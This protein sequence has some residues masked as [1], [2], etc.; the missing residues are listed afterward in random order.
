MM[1]VEARRAERV[2]SFLRARIVFNNH[3]T[4]IECTIKNI[5]A[6]GAKI[7]LSN[8][9]SIPETFVLEVPQKGRSHRAKLSWRNETSIGVEFLDDEPGQV[10]RGEIERLR[11]ENR[12]LRGL[13]AR[14]TH[15]L[16][17]LGQS[18]SD[19]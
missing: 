7:E 19:D 13:V 12:T 16:E 17:Q 6:G 14:L 1:M 10:E 5:S 15:R 4:T 3:N 8:T 2:R 11:Q 18:V 9:M